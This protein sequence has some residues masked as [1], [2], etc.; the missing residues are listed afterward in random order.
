MF[1][2]LPSCRQGRLGREL[3]LCGAGD[4]PA[5][6]RPKSLARRNGGVWNIEVEREAIY[7]R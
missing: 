4:F 2:V 1:A 3:A 7:I 6:G 5:R